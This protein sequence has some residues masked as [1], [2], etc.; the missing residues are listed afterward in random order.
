MK[1]AVI[2]FTCL[3]AIVT[4]RPEILLHDEHH[5]HVPDHIPVEVEHVKLESKIE[6][7]IGDKKIEIAVLVPSTLK[8]TTDNTVAETS[9]KVYSSPKKWKS[10]SASRSKQPRAQFE[11]KPA[12]SKIQYTTSLNLNNS[13]AQN[14]T[15]EKPEHHGEHDEARRKAKHYHDMKI[16]Q[17]ESDIEENGKYHY[18]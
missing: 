13:S 14:A 17:L 12:E 16:V 15:E 2:I 1:T 3:I 5:L 10:A 6:S 11:E 9:E 18:G 4:A 8:P 7:K